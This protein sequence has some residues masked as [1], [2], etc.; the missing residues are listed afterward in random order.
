MKRKRSEN[1]NCNS[2]LHTLRPY[3]AIYGHTWNMMKFRLVLFLLSLSV[4]IP[5]RVFNRFAIAKSKPNIWKCLQAV[6]SVTSISVRSKDIHKAEQFYREGLHL[7]TLIMDDTLR[8]TLPSG[9]HVFFR[10]DKELLLDRPCFEFEPDL[11]LNR[12]FFD[13]VLRE[14][15]TGPNAHAIT[16]EDRDF[17][18]FQ[19]YKRELLNCR[20]FADGNVV[21]FCFFHC[22]SFDLYIRYILGLLWSGHYS[23]REWNNKTL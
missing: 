23:T 14:V 15:E 18:D 11:Y 6:P 17:R 10:E 1:V 2:R 19:N 22:L 8:V 9:T 7:E 16:E 20:A 21:F 3:P 12:E 4:C 5:Y 13:D